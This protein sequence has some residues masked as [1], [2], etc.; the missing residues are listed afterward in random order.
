MDLCH[1]LEGRGLYTH[2]ACKETRNLDLDL[3]RHYKYESSKVEEFCKLL[4]GSIFCKKSKN[5]FLENENDF[6]ICVWHF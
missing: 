6:L 3:R 5:S 4:L 2:I 1:N